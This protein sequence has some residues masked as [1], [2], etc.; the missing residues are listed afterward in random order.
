MKTSSSMIEK[1]KKYEGWSSTAYWDSTGKVWTIGYGTTTYPNGKKVKQGDVITKA[2]G[3]QYFLYDVE[4]HAAT[5]E[6]Y[7]KVPLTQNQFDALSSFNY[8]LGPYALSNTQL[9]S[10]INKNDWNSAALQIQKF[11]KS[12]GVTLAGLTKR[13]KEEAALL[14]NNTQGIYSGLSGLP[15]TY[16]IGSLYDNPL[17]DSLGMDLSALGQGNFS[18]TS[19]DTILD[20]SN[21]V[22]YMI[23]ELT[24]I[25]P[26][27]VSTV[28]NPFSW[29]F[30]NTRAISLRTLIVVVGLMLIWFG[31][32]KLSGGLI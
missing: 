15:G 1:L 32:K 23:D 9:L 4:R 13:R 29:V 10:Y 28:T 25:K 30:D 21:N 12:G 17:L 24:K 26:F 31:I 5:I 3:E 14:L 2:Q 20:D 18:S 7:V 8:N 11:D 6:K 19:T 27:N 22:F 16:N